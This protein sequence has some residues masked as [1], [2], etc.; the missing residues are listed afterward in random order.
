MKISL[1]KR[2]AQQLVVA[3]AVTWGA[4][5]LAGSVAGTGGGTEVTQLM[6]NIELVTQN[7][8]IVEGY[9]RQGLQYDTQLRNLIKNP[10]SMFG[11]EAGALMRSVG[12]LM[13]SGQAIG[14]SMYEVDRRLGQRYTNTQAMSFADRF[15]SWTNGSKGNLEASMRAAG[16]RRDQYK[17]DA[18]ALD[19]L[20][21]KAQNDQGA[22]A[23]AQTAAEINIQNVRQ[24]QALGDMLAEQ[25]AVTAEYRLA[26][27]D[28]EQA[29]QDANRKIMGEKKPYTAKSNKN[30]L[31]SN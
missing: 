1:K 4:S 12:A 10:A 30:Y 11:P 2:Y 23:A 14:S 15:R 28:K 6:N 22:A 24:M 19:A 16:M 3:I 25:H 18:A 7:A 26:A 5:A 8:K 27:L 13:D 20:Y 21:A 17:S 9:V 31:L 29:V